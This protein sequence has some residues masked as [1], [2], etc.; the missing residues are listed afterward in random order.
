MCDGRRQVA[1]RIARV[2]GAGSE[3]GN[4]R[5]GSRS[6]ARL[7]LLII[8]VF[9]A[10]KFGVVSVPAGRY[11]LRTDATGFMPMPNGEARVITVKEA[12]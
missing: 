12:Q 6:L 11:A 8:A 3:S 4:G 9:L 7:V 2:E 5:T 1:R 10:M